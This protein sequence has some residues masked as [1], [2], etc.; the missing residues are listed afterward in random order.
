M[1]AFTIGRASDNSL[2]INDASVSR[3][4]AQLYN[5]LGKWYIIDLNSTHGSKVNGI[6]IKE[7]VELKPSDIIILSDVKLHFDGRAIL[8]PQG[9]Q[10]LVLNRLAASAVS[11]CNASY[12]LDRVVPQHPKR[13]KLPAVAGLITLFFIIAL[14]LIA[15][16]NNKSEP[17][18]SE[19]IAIPPS[20]QAVL[21]YVT[22]PYDGGEY[23]GWVRDGLPHG[24]G[25]LKYPSIGRS[26][27][28]VDLLLHRG[29]KAKMYEGE[30]QNGLKHGFG[31]LTHPDGK[32]EEGYWDIG[33]FIGHSGN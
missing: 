15:V 24:Q 14:L 13:S 25:T 32:I 18:V 16:L 7:A 4:H 23:T 20:R 21:E 2:V 22:I 33:Q 27:A 1:D 8:S 26:S 30:W 19:H 29:N 12:P 9:K 11:P 3:Y 28:F 5:S 6:N 17:Q 10:L 31:K